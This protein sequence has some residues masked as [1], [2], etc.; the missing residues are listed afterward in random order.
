MRSSVLHRTSGNHVRFVL[1][2]ETYYDHYLNLIK[3]SKKSVHL[4]TYIFD[5]DKFGIAVHTELKNAA[6][7]G[8]QVYLLIDSVGSLNFSAEFEKELHDSGV[9]FCRFNGVQFKWL[10]QWG[11]RLHH[12]VLLVDQLQAL[13]G[14]INVV[15]DSYNTKSVPHQLDFAVY[16]EG[17]AMAGLTQ[18][19]QTIFQK[20]CSKKIKF[21]RDH[22]ERK[23]DINGVDL[24][25]SINDWIYHRWQITKQYSELT[26]T[27]KNEIIILNSYFF[28]RKK[29][30]KQL[31]A[32]AKRGV[33]VRLIL[34]KISDWPS[35]VLATQYLYD[36]FLKNGVEI[37]QW[38]ES[39]M[40]G[41]LA[42][43]DGTWST[44]GSFNLNYTSYQQNLEMNVDIY[45]EIFTKQLNQKL[46]VLID[47][48]CEKI[49]AHEFIAKAPLSVRIS[50]F[51]FYILLNAVANFSIGLAFQEEENRTRIYKRV[52]IA[53]SLGF[54]ILGIIG[55]VLPIVP[56]VPF[57]VISILLVYRQILFNNKNV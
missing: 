44:I 23:L 6:L 32:A 28:P 15:S 5:K 46:Q 17:P 9:H 36:Y 16:V 43:I 56:S 45:S 53:A 31:A 20:A 21:K 40:H 52:H 24:K 26:E 48:G 27:A 50:R 57:F 42:S 47:T 2:G 13:I 38:K 18:Y 14:G 54:F 29:F 39:F 49:E 55:A 35:Y 30:M 37:Y 41:K 1:E 33:R 34:P 25:I 51:F 19:C 11:R 3:N 8:V 4:Q 22:I 7:R 12:K 10:G